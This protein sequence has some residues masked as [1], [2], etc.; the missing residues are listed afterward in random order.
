M[1]TLG[2]TFDKETRRVT[3]YITECD[4]F[5]DYYS[6]QYFMLDADDFI[7]SYPTEGYGAVCI[8]NV[9]YKILKN[10][11]ID[12]VC[13]TYDIESVV[14]PDATTDI[15]E[16]CFRHCAKLKEITL[17]KTMT[18]I[19]PYTFSH[20]YS[21]E[22]IALP[23]SITRIYAWSFRFCISLKVI[24]IPNTFIFI[25]FLGLRYAV[26]G[27]ASFFGDNAMQHI[28]VRFGASD[29]WLGTATAIFKSL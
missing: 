24:S 15:G 6:T 28:D 19:K 4:G 10:D 16:G 17:P 22:S 7:R 9:W 5:N 13:K 1:K 11:H 18:A 12:T 8:N 3:C 20:C 23:D 27:S 2:Y 14:L 25:G 21:L 29:D 26:P